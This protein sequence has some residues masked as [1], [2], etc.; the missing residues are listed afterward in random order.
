MKFDLYLELFSHKSD[1]QF[2]C[3][4]SHRPILVSC[5]AAYCWTYVKQ[6]TWNYIFRYLFYFLLETFSEFIFTE[7]NMK[8]HLIFQS[9]ATTD[10]KGPKVVSYLTLLKKFLIIMIW[11]QRKAPMPFAVTDRR[12]NF[13]IR[14]S[15]LPEVSCGF[16]Q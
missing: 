8:F 16:L 12:K 7:I 15:L 5:K 13:P 11:H 9:V 2:M 6:C 14:H 3:R 4:M 10:Q 1:M